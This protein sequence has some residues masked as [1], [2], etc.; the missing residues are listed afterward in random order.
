[1]KQN[2]GNIAKLIHA[3]QLE[4]KSMLQGVLDSKE[5]LSL[6]LYASYLSMQYWL[7]K[8]VQ[9]HFLGVA[10]HEDLARHKS[11]R[12][13]LVKFAYEEEHH[14][15]I[16][17]KDLKALGLEPKTIQLDIKLW[18]SYFKKV[19]EKTPF[20]R[21][22]ATCIL[23]NI[24]GGCKAELDQLLGRADY[25][26]PKTTRFLTIHRHEEIPHGDEIIEALEACKLNEKEISQLEQGAAEGG[27][28]FLR[29]LQS[30]FFKKSESKIS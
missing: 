30:C 14:Y 10:A 26:S 1:M 23:E 17:A 7:T 2:L 8:G 29:M 28:L 25:I 18:H 15:L 4:L 22:G 11:L 27:T 16:A 9:K 3:S 5:G 12:E 19:V 24:S 20:V 13:F 21:L 6:D